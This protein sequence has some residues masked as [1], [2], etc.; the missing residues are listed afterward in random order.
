MQAFRFAFLT[1]VIILCSSCASLS[2]VRDQ[3]F[4]CPYDTVW[5]TA[6]HTMKDRPLILKDKEKGQIET[7]WVEMAGDGRTFGMFGR[8]GFGDKQRA[9]LSMALK[10]MNDVTMVTLSEYREQWHR[11]GGVTSQATKWWPVEP[12]EQDIEAVLTSL[13]ARLKE[14]GCS[15]T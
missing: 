13:N 6:V 14:R 5:E 9:R 15:P 2:G 3:Y 8:E 4:V 12:S 11:K 10:Q 7:A 1:S